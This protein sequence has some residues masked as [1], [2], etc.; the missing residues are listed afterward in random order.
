MHFG[1]SLKE[2]RDRRAGY[3]VVRVGGDI[4]ENWSLPVKV[5]PASP[6]KNSGM[7][8]TGFCP[9]FWDYRPVRRTRR[10]PCALNHPAN[11]TKRDKT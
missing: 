2:E 3:G 10:P 4:R 8:L 9:I 5:D 6:N 1:R 7:R 11:V